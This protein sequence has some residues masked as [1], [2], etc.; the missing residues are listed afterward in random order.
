VAAAGTVAVAE[1]EERASETGWVAAATE[2]EMMMMVAEERLMAAGLMAPRRY[3]MSGRWA[4][5]ETEAVVAA[6]ASRARFVVADWAARAYR[7]GDSDGAALAGVMA[8]PHA[9]KS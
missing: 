7:D 9:W 5:M 8:A 4:V 1:E 3:G 6:R 2:A